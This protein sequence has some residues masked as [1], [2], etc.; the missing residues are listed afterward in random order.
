[1]S[2]AAQVIAYPRYPIASGN[3][4]G[5]AGVACPV[6]PQH[7]HF[8][9]RPQP[10]LTGFSLLGFSLMLKEVHPVGWLPWCGRPRVDTVVA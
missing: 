3:Q 10:R 1:V 4:G 5:V 8:C 6:T 7:A 9:P 2:G